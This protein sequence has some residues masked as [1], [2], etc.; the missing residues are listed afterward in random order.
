MC[1]VLRLQQTPCIPSER[2]SRAARPQTFSPPSSVATLRLQREAKMFLQNL[3]LLVIS[4]VMMMIK[5]ARMIILH[6]SW[7]IKTWWWWQLLRESIR[8]L[9]GFPASTF[10]LTVD[11]FNCVT[12]SYIVFHF[13]TKCN[14]FLHCVRFGYIVLHI[15]LKWIFTTAL[16]H[17]VLYFVTIGLLHC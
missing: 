6:H 17:C 8:P 10:S 16:S 15:W 3:V 2:K 5:W 4:S 13:A 11:L 1:N 14:T 12:L 7:M 9:C